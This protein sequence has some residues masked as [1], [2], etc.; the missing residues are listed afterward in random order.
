MSHPL[1]SE[2]V[3]ANLPNEVAVSDRNEVIELETAATPT[4]G[5]PALL[6]NDVVQ[7]EFSDLDVEPGAAEQVIESRI[8]RFKVE[9]RVLIRRKHEQEGKIL[10]EC[11]A[12]KQIKAPNVKT[13]RGDPLLPAGLID[14]YLVGALA[15]PARRNSY[16]H[17]PITVVLPD[18]SVP[19]IHQLVAVVL[20]LLAE[21]VE[22][23]PGFMTGRT[24]QAIL[25]REG[26]ERVRITGGKEEKD[27]RQQHT[28]GETVPGRGHRVLLVLRQTGTTG[29]SY[30]EPKATAPF[31]HVVRGPR[32]DCKNCKC[33]QA[34]LLG[35]HRNIMV[36][37]KPS[38]KMFNAKLQSILSGGAVEMVRP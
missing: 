9:D 2:L 1:Q 30:N 7:F 14:G 22:H 17:R 34:H 6:G 13:V 28:T 4:K 15:V 37:R 38:R 20:E 10:V 12:R 3:V 19:I 35:E 21:V 23:R 32:F 11:A 18:R 29:S 8:D 5:K 26:R 25:S 16:G 31:A 36:A 24:A 33:V 27:R